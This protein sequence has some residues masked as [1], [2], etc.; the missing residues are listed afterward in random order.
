MNKK[1]ARKDSH[2]SNANPQNQLNIQNNIFMENELNAIRKLPEPLANRAFALLEKTAEHKMQMDR[3]ILELEKQEQ[4]NRVSDSH[5]FY[6]L[7]SLG[8]ITAFI[9][10]VG[11]LGIFAY[12][13]IQDKPNAWL[14]LLPAIITSVAKLGKIKKS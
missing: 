10:I 2:S 9:Y 12:L 4:K 3:E 8:A 5:W 7:Q 13:V 11:S 6:R 1:P 14:S